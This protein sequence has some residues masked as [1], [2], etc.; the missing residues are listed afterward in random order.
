[1]TDSESP[2]GALS[3]RAFA[4]TL[5]SGA[6]LAVAAPAVAITD[7]IRKVNE[8]VDI[9]V[10][11]GWTRTETLELEKVLESLGSTRNPDY[12][13][14]VVAES[15]LQREIAT[16][17]ICDGNAGDCPITPATCEYFVSM[18]RA[19]DP[20]RSEDN[21]EEILHNVSIWQVDRT[22]VD[23]LHNVDSVKKIYSKTL[24][25]GAKIRAAISD[26][27]HPDM[28][29]KMNGLRRYHHLVV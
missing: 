4:G 27:T 12:A 1:M 7:T 15:I 16:V 20:M 5:L 18:S 22:H 25:G 10:R 3:R 11:T 9:F 24:R 29:E 23:G 17:A 6:G 2:T 14:A 13:N 21:A 8:P 26:C 28:I 19:A